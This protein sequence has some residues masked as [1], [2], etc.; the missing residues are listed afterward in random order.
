VAV[1][2]TPNF[3][4]NAY[5]VSLQLTAGPGNAGATVTAKLGDSFTINDAVGGN[6]FDY[7][8]IYGG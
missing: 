3:P 4:D 7:T 1:Q 8:L 2:L 6:T 5:N